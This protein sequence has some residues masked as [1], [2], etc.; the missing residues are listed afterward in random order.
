MFV[1]VDSRFNIVS[2]DEVLQ[3]NFIGWLNNSEMNLLVI[4][5]FI[6]NIGYHFINKILVKARLRFDLL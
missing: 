1:R 2:L 5:T 4:V 6:P 3:S